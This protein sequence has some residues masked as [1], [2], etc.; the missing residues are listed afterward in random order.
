MLGSPFA[1]PVRMLVGKGN[2]VVSLKEG[3]Y[4]LPQVHLL[5]GSIDH[6]EAI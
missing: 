6:C 1:R 3:R 2:G 4:Q 5:E